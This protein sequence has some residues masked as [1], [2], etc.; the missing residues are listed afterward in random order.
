MERH[1]QLS[2]RGTERGEGGEQGSVILSADLRWRI[3]DD[4]LNGASFPLH[5]SPHCTCLDL[6][7]PLPRLFIPPLHPPLSQGTIVIRYA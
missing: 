3:A 1:K 6:S 2:R 4:K 7:P 5:S